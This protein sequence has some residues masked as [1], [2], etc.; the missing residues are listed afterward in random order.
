MCRAAPTPMG[1]EWATSTRAECTASDG[2]R[3]NR[4]GAFRTPHRRAYI[5]TCYQAAHERLEATYPSGT[6]NARA[7]LASMF[8]ELAANCDHLEQAAQ[9]EATAYENEAT[10]SPD[11][12]TAALRKWEAA[13]LDGL[14]ALDN[15]RSSQLCIDCACE[16]V[17]TV[18]SGLGQRVCSRCLREG[19]T[20]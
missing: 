14:A 11:A 6:D 4:A 19:A 18:V 10:A 17:D 9:R 20:S 7:E 12:F 5:L 1:E 8:P 3:H 16:S 2:G 15:A 13:T